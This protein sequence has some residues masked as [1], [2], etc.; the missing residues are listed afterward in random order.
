MEPLDRAQASATS[1]EEIRQE[2]AQ[3]RAEVE[4]ARRDA[5]EYASLLRETR[6]DFADYRRQVARER[7]EQDAQARISLLLSVVP[8]L[9]ELQ[10]CL[11]V[12]PDGRFSPTWTE[13]LQGVERR[14]RQVLDSE[15]IERIDALGALYNPWEHEAIQSQASPELEDQRVLAVLR[16][17][18]RIGDRVIRPARVVVARRTR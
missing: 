15:G 6:A 18:Y 13:R 3:L 9:E 7:P 11:A 10:A 16:E 4:A 12:S 14:L 2:L 5:D 17:G 1:D 8:A